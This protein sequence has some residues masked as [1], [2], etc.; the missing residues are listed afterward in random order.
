MKPYIRKNAI[1]TIGTDGIMGNKLI[2]INAQG[3]HTK[4]IEEGDTIYSRKAV[5]T[6]EMLRT[7]STTNSN[8]ERITHNLYEIT[9]KLNN[10]ESLW[11]LLS[12]T[13][14]TQ[15]IKNAISEFRKAGLNTAQMTNTGKNLALTLSHGNG[16]IPKLFTDTTLSL[17]LASS[18]QQIQQASKETVGVLENLKKVIHTMEQGEGTVSLLLR[19]TVLRENIS[20]SGMNIEQG[21]RGF[22][23]NMEALKSNV[24]FK[25]YFKNQEKKKRKTESKKQ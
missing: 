15:D 4:S 13:I 9:I 6:E 11:M 2:N 3:N 19:D 12:D 16:L 5:E 14:I 17:Q 21:T 25:G 24:L 23:Q 1:A 18:M 7:L 8:M 22:N 10:N 20:K